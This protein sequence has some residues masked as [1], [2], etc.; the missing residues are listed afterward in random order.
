M[1]LVWVLILT[2][3]GAAAYW[4]WGAFEGTPPRIT[5]LE[6]VTFVGAPHEHEFTIMDEE[7]GVE[8]ARVYVIAGGKEYKLTSASWEGTWHSGANEKTPRRV[9]TTISP[10]DLGLPQG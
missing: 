9:Q 6:T 1:K 3:A 7:R 2:A 8:S 4:A 5:T 10:A